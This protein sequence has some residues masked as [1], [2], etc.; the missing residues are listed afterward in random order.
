MD[1]DKPQMKEARL[2]LRDNGIKVS[3]IGSPVGKVKL[4]E[5]FDLHL[6]KFK[7]SVD[8]ADFFDTKLIRMFSYYPPEG[9]NIDDFRRTIQE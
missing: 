1:L 7:H 2:I 3:A 4:D 5:P 8:L 9:E 6:D